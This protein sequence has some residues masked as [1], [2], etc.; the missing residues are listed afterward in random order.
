MGGMGEAL[1]LL[2][3]KTALFLFS[4]NLFLYY[5]FR[6]SQFELCSPNMA[7]GPLLATGDP[8]KHHDL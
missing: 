2:G 1:R 5:Y 6:G 8:R 3:R 7:V 4:E